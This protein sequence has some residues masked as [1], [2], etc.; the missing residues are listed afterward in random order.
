MEDAIKRKQLKPW[1]RFWKIRL[2]E[3]MNPEW[4]N[5]YDPATG[6]IAFGSADRE[7]TRSLIFPTDT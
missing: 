4:S 2:I 3:D 6:A 1:Q 5:R 7:A